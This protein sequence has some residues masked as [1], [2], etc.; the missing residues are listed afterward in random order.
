MRITIPAVL[1]IF[2]TLASV[3]SLAKINFSNPARETL[4]IETLDIGKSDFFDFVKSTIL[5]KKPGLGKYDRVAFSPC[6]IEIDNQKI[7][8]YRDQKG[9]EI[10]FFSNPSCNQIVIRRVLENSYQY[11]KST[12]TGYQNRQC[13]LNVER[14]ISPLLEYYTIMYEER[15][16]ENCDICDFKEKE[17]IDIILAT[18][19]E[20]LEHCKS[21]SD[22]VIQFI[23]E[24]DSHIESTFK[25]KVSQ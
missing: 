11:N 17:R 18:Q 23:S 15:K 8:D 1:F 21:Q 14:I 6:D 22:N 2:F 24:L 13:L 19:K 25:V 5:D 9:K 20:V 4:D 10:K 3:S 7:I 16:K 12:I